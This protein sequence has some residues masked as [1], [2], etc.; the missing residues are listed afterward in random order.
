[1]NIPETFFSVN[2]ELR[3]FGLSC[4]LGAADGFSCDFS[5]FQ[6]VFVLICKK[7]VGKFVGS[8]KNFV[9]IY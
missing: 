1:M 7:A 5:P 9:Q 2:E 4:L 6:A 3:L 8:S